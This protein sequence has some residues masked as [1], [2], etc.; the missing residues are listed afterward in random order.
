MLALAG[1]FGLLLTHQNPLYYLLKEKKKEKTLWKALWKAPCY[2]GIQII[3]LTV[4][5]AL[6]SGT[7][8]Y[9]TEVII[10]A[11]FACG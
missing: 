10:N 4:L 3:F 6:N 1:M 5:L 11:K 7:G 2:L 8:L 9:S